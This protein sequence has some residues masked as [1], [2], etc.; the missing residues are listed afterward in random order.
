MNDKLRL[1]FMFEAIAGKLGIQKS[2]ILAIREP[3]VE[4]SIGR[5]VVYLLKQRHLPMM[6][7]EEFFRLTGVSLRTYSSEDIT[8]FEEFLTD[9]A[10]NN[11][12]ALLS[13]HKCNEADEEELVLSLRKKAS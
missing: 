9:I 6:T 1:G 13:H 7:S 8:A 5:R 2:E 3:T 12:K 10:D 4:V 11:Y